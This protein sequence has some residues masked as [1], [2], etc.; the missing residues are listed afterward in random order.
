[1]SYPGH[2]EDGLDLWV[3]I[4]KQRLFAILNRKG[5]LFT[6]DK[7]WEVIKIICHHRQ[8]EGCGVVDMDKID[9]FPFTKRPYFQEKPDIHFIGQRGCIKRYIGFLKPLMESPRFYADNKIVHLGI[10][11]QL[12]AEVFN[13]IFTPSPVPGG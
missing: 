3:V 11:L 4:F 9:F 1:M 8:A 6:E 10:V 13:M 7:G 12:E 5:G 2:T